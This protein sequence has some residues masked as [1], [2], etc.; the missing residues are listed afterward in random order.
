MHHCTIQLLL[1]VGVRWWLLCREFRFRLVSVFLLHPLFKD[2]D[3]VRRKILQ[4]RS[5]CCWS[6]AVFCIRNHHQKTISSPTHHILMWS[7]WEVPET[8]TG[9]EIPSAIPIALP[10]G[11]NRPQVITPAVAGSG[12]APVRDRPT[13]LVVGRCPSEWMLGAT[14]AGTGHNTATSCARTRG[15]CAAAWCCSR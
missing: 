10:S 5:R 3:M 13:S 7:H 11:L 4:S 6:I 8:T 9:V 1:L 2:N 15:P 12:P 14:P